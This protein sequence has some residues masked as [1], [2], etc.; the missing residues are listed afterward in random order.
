MGSK[1][2]YVPVMMFGSVLALVLAIWS[3]RF[4]GGTAV[5]GIASLTFVLLGQIVGLKW[6]INA[7][8]VGL[9]ASIPCWIFLAWRLYSSVD[10][11]DV[12]IDRSLFVFLPLMS[13]AM[14]Y[15]GAYLGRWMAIRRKM[16]SALQNK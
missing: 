8:M 1:L 2:H 4:G 12:A 15:I 16:K 6:P 10:P 11:G 3:F 13:M 9:V 14:S 7:W 5:L